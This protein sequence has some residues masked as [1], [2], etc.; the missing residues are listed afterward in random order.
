MKLGEVFHSLS[1]EQL[2]YTIFYGSSI[3]FVTAFLC[4]VL[5]SY[6]DGKEYFEHRAGRRLAERVLQ[7]VG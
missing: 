5:F 4:K 2:E 6:G 3:L 7:L 1:P